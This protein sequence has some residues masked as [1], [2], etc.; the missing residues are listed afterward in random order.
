MLKRFLIKLAPATLRA[1]LPWLAVLMLAVINPLACLIHC[2]IMHGV[3]QPASVHE[4]EHY[5][6]SLD[7]AEA[8]LQAHLTHEAAMQAKQSALLPSFYHKAAFIHNQIPSDEPHDPRAS[9]TPRAV[10]ESLPLLIVLIG[11]VISVLAVVAQLVE[12][13]TSCCNPPLL[14][15]PRWA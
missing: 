1:T 8:A 3:H 5:I 12:K 2:T 13:L 4:H 6:C 7:K 15:P 9:L 11:F 10:Y 14:P